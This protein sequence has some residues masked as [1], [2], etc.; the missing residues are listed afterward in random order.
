MELDKEVKSDV[1]EL[2]EMKKRSYFCAYLI[3][4]DQVDSAKEVMLRTKDNQAFLPLRAKLEDEMESYISS[5]DLSSISIEDI[6]ITEITPVVKSLDEKQ[7]KKLKGLIED[8]IILDSA[9]FKVE[10]EKKFNDCLKN[11]NIKVKDIPVNLREQLPKRFTATRK[12]FEPAIRNESILEREND[13]ICRRNLIYKVCR[14]GRYE[15][16]NNCLNAASDAQ[17]NPQISDLIT[18]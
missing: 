4:K 10:A 17:S 6:T 2:D 8:V 12:V 13:I 16:L 5:S 3:H 9:N 1:V 15:E 14:E 18:K 7:L 11:M